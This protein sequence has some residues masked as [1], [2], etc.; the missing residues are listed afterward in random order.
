MGGKGV[1]RKYTMIKW[2][3]TG[4][5]WGGSWQCYLCCDT[6]HIDTQFQGISREGILYL[7][8]NIRNC[9]ET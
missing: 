7:S 6:V 1:G 5:G 3:G 9:I 2:K 8:E 4:K